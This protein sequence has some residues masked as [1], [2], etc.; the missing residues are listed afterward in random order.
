[1]GFIF[2]L[3]NEF[4]VDSPRSLLFPFSCPQWIFLVVTLTIYLWQFLPNKIQRR[5]QFS[6]GVYDQVLFSLMGLFDFT[7][8]YSQPP[9]NGENSELGGFSID[10]VH[11]TSESTDNQ[12]SSFSPVGTT[13]LPLC[14]VRH[15]LT[16]E[17][18]SLVVS[19]SVMFMLP[20][21]RQITKSH[22]PVQ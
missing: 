3:Y 20:L 22:L 7:V 5:H 19:Q 13:P 16:I 17:V 15:L 11:D 14:L 8:T 12:V 2:K 6:H 1:M 18:L 21:N 10:Y 9:L 4:L